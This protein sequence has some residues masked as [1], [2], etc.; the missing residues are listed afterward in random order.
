LK[1]GSE[2]NRLDFIQNTWSRIL[3][4]SY[5]IQ[6]SLFIQW[7]NTLFYP[8]NGINRFVFIQLSNWKTNQFIQL[9]VG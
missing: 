3:S 4:N 9:F 2:D 5:F 6:Q 1:S 8:T 7:Q